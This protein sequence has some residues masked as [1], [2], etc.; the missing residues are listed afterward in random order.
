[1]AKATGT[2]PDAPVALITG[3]GTGIGEAAARLLA[4][5]GTRVAIVG[6]RLEPLTRVADAIAGDGGAAHALQADLGAPGA[7]HAVVA[8]VLDAWG[9]IDAVVNNAAVIQVKPLDHFTIADFDHHVAVNVRAPYFLVQAALPA[10]RISPAPVVVNV[11]SVAAAMYRPRQTLYGL[12]KAALEHLTMN[13]AAELAPDGIRVA[14]VRPGPVETPIH[15]QAV[16][17]PA[18][19]LAELARLVPLGRLA[20]PDEVARWIWQLVDREAAWVTGTVITVDG[21]RILGPP[22]TA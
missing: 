18:A 20:Q 3:G 13:L 15:T 7:P 14:C 1:M 4:A 17:D 8:G 11:S 12:T 16:D 6:R 9:R 22:A 10:L 19:R 5:R 21:G 2:R